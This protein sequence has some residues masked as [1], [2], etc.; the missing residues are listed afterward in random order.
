MQWSEE[1]NP[2]KGIFSPVLLV[3]ILVQVVCQRGNEYFF[4]INSLPV[5]TLLTSGLRA[6]MLIRFRQ[7]YYYA[8]PSSLQCFCCQES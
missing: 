3:A 2:V 4:T 8:L 7:S 1:R 5:V 6:G